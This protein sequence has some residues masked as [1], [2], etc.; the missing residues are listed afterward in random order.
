VATTGLLLLAILPVLA[1]EAPPEKLP[2]PGGDGGG[3]TLAKCLQ[4]ALD[5]QP[6]LMAHRASLAAAQTQQQALQRMRGPAVVAAPDLP[7]RRQQACIGV[8]ISEAGLRQA[9]AEVIYNVTRLYW[10][11][12]YARTQKEIVEE[13]AGS[14]KVIHDTVAAQ[15]KEKGAPKEWTQS[16]VDKLLVYQRIAESKIEEA[17]QGEQRALAALREAIGLCGD[18]VLQVPEEPLPVPAAKLSKDEIVAM[19]RALRGEVIQAS[20]AVELFDLEVTAQGRHIL[21]GT[22]NTF[23]AGGDIH[24]RLIPQD[25]T[26]GE[27]HPGGLPPEMP[28][29]LVG[30]RGNR[31]QRARDFLARAQA[32]AQKTENLITLEATDFYHRALELQLKVAILGQAAEAG[33]RLAKETRLDFA[34]LQKVKIEDVLTNLVVGAQARSQY[35]EALWQYLLALAGLERV[36]AGGFCAGFGK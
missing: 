2:A 23:A 15:I 1:E 24:A 34:S 30:S 26:N 9:E 10:T 6:S 35:N 5:Q 25:R 32:I 8:A 11:V 12:Q 27:Y 16:T 14:F 4:Q 3:L 22:V 18:V 36:T 29:M 7:L 31:M 21:P 33:Q 13:V 20:R 28:A 17:V 19:A